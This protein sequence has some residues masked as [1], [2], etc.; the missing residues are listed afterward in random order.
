MPH[1]EIGAAAVEHGFYRELPHIVRIQGV[2][3]IVIC[4]SVA[5]PQ[6]RGA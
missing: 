4:R 6:M 3:N 5:A 1:Q 2:T